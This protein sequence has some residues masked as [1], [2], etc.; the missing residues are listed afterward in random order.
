MSRYGIHRPKK[1]NIN[2][3]R[4]NRFFCFSYVKIY[5][6]FTEKFQQNH[7]YLHWLMAPYFTRSRSG[8]ETGHFWWN[9][10]N[11]MCQCRAFWIIHKK[12]FIIFP[13]PATPFICEKILSCAV[14]C[15]DFTF[16]TVALSIWNT[17]ANVLF[18]TTLATDYGMLRK[19]RYC[20]RS[21]T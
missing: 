9:I 19:R 14:S 7:R 6:V 10:Y 3:C 5:K 12:Q 15:H 4:I 1:P 13:D 18:W 16:I 21:S 2:F 11:L 17:E 8:S 20:Q